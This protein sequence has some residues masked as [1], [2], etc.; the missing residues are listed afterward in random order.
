MFYCMY[1]PVLRMTFTC[2]NPTETWYLNSRSA[3]DYSILTDC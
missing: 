3:T 1:V 2:H